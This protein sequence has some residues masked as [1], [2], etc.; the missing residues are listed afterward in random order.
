MWPAYWKVNKSLRSEKEKYFSFF[1]V[2]I[3]FGFGVILGG[4]QDLLKAQVEFK[5]PDYGFGI[6]TTLTD[7]WSHGRQVHSLTVLLFLLPHTTHPQ[8]TDC[9]PLALIILYIFN[10]AL[11]V[12]WGPESYFLQYWAW[13]AGLGIR[14]E[15][16]LWEENMFIVLEDWDHIWKFLG[17][18]TGSLGEVQGVEI[19]FTRN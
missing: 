6:E 10:P 15:A 5:G 13:C 14:W 2:F 11:L 9:W 18:I 16:M 1:S 3:F 8:C 12:G 17:F 19:I 7:C 4:A